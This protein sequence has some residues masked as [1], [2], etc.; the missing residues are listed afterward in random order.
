MDFAVQ[1]IIVYARQ[2]GVH[3]ENEAM[4]LKLLKDKH[5][6]L[7]SC[8]NCKRFNSNRGYESVKCLVCRSEVGCYKCG[9]QVTKKYPHMTLKAARYLETLDEEIALCA[10]CKEKHCTECLEYLCKDDEHE[11][12]CRC[13]DCSCITADRE[14]KKRNISE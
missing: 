8:K 10:D 14:S 7:H 13:T 3:K 11:A 2:M 4:M 9:E 5:V 6:S 12:P 1:R